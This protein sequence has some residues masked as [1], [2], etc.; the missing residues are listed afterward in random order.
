MPA[1]R[2]N[3]LMA[4]RGVVGIR[5]SAGRFDALEVIDRDAAIA[6]NGTKANPALAGL[7]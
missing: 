4:A 5:A 1:N 2:I 7:G 3:A 6:S